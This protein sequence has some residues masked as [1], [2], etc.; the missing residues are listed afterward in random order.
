[1]I[2]DKGFLSNKELYTEWEGLGE[3][4]NSLNTCLNLKS[5]PG[6]IVSYG[7]NCTEIEE[8][9]GCTIEEL[10]SIRKTKYKAEG[11]RG[12]T[13]FCFADFSDK[14]QTNEEYLESKFEFKSEQ[15]G[16]EFRTNPQSSKDVGGSG[17]GKDDS[18][19]KTDNQLYADILNRR[20]NI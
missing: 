17:S 16:E 20:K 10:K 15:W 1:M 13:G 12:E 18:D 19:K 6:D 8:G 4:S 14:H 7:E 9:S 2:K 11:D 3:S 5:R